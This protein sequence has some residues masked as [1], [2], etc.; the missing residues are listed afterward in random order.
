MKLRQIRSIAAVLPLLTLCAAGV[1][2]AQNVAQDKAAAPKPE[3][4]MQ[5]PSAEGAAEMEAMMKAGTPGEPHKK[6]ARMVG[7][8]TYSTKA[9]MDPSQPPVE[10]KGTMRGQAILGGR[11]VEQ[12]WKATS[13]ACSSRAAARKATTT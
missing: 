2:V 8:W 7:D 4:S 11:Y 6:L 12:T 9:W 10:S 1:A 3:V 13:W 5:A